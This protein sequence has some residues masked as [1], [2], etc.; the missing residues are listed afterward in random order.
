M[1]A[2]ATAVLESAGRPWGPGTR[3]PGAVT[4]S[5][6]VATNATRADLAGCKF[7]LVGAENT[8][9]RYQSRYDFC[10]APV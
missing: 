7:T 10:G 9:S 2:L 4:I 6:L 1:Q 5:L 3:V 8:Q